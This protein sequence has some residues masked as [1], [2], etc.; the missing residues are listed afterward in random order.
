MSK[1]ENS[2]GSN[3]QCSRACNISGCR[4]KK[5][6]IGRK[7]MEWSK[8]WLD[9]WTSAL[10]TD[11]LLYGNNELEVP[12]ISLQLS[13]IKTTQKTWKGAVVCWCF[14]GGKIMWTLSGKLKEWVSRKANEQGE[15]KVMSLLF[16]SL[17][18]RGTLTSTLYTSLCLYITASIYRKYSG[19]NSCLA[20]LCA[21]QSLSLFSF[22]SFLSCL[23]SLTH[24]HNHTGVC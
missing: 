8:P 21:C 20:F 16:L 17:P 14:G 7:W 3:K 24:T 2:T 12:G 22:S 18:P 1:Q 15:K 19:L 6:M 13:W 9:E 4:G 11:R 23:I 5:E 10:K